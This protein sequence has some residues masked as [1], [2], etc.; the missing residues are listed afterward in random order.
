MTPKD[1]TVPRAITRLVAPRGRSD[2]PVAPGRSSEDYEY[3]ILT[4]PRGE[5][6]GSVRRSLS[7]EA[8]YG[9]WD[10]ARTRIY[11][12][13]ARRVWLRRRITRIVSTLPETSAA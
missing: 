9:R 4:I 1:H 10:L 12:G 11:L 7:E 13:G 6:I 2:L 8:E 3:R 5:S